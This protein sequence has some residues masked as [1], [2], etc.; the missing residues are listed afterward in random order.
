MLNPCD[1]GLDNAGAI[2]GAKLL[3]QMVKDGIEVAGADYSMV[4]GLFNG[5]KLA[6][7]IGGPWTLADAQKANINYGVAAIPTIGGKSPKVF[8][9]VQGFE[10]SAFSANKVLANLFVKDFLITKAVMLRLFELGNRPPAYLPA[11]ADLSGNADIQGF[12]AS[13]ANGTPM[14]KIPQM[15]SVWSAWS[16]ALAL[17]V[18]QT[19]DPADRDE[20]RGEPD[21]YDARLPDN[22]GFSGGAGH[23]R[24]LLL[25]MRDSFLLRHGAKILALGILCALAIYATSSLIVM[26]SYGLAALPVI[27]AGIITYIF[28]SERRYPLRWLVP[29]LLFLFV[30]VIYP[31]GYTFVGSLTDLGTGH[32][33]PK[34]QAIEQLL[35]RTYAPPNAE[36]Y[37]YLLFQDSTGSL[38]FLLQN[39]SQAI[40]V[41]GEQATA[42]TLPDARFVDENGDGQPDRFLDY[43]RLEMR[44]IVALLPTLEQ[45][46]VTYEGLTLGVDSLTEFR[47][48]MPKYSYDAAT[49]TMTDLETGTTYTAVEGIFTSPS[50]EEIYPGYRVWVGF[51]NYVRLVTNPQISGPF[52]RVFL[53][54]I[55]FA[56]LS[57][58]VT[59]AFGLGLAILL[60]DPHLRAR[61]LYRVLVIVPYAIPSF[62]TI[63]VW[64]GMLNQNFGVINQML[65]SLFGAGARVPWLESAWVARATCLLVNLWLGYPYMMIVS[66]GALQSIPHE[67]YE[68][69]RVDGASRWQ[70]FRKITLPM[71][72]MPLAPLLVG[73]FAFNFNNF[74]LIYLLTQGQP[75]LSRT[76]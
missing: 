8:V 49:E 17:I 60:N 23:G 21:P 54:T 5:G 62:V 52:V 58:A 33:L 76:H 35:G 30:M 31:I 3:D 29:G 43:R 57:V 53:W 34:N 71:L 50:G 9:G 61:S 20:E 26:G 38:A 22:V 63:L 27:A 37:T 72:L 24:P 73:S 42:I 11:L 15:D 4:T 67:L 25:P 36:R 69:S 16:D 14:P 59:F 28:L 56:A 12:A 55:A 68:A 10:I 1:I 46:R 2:A 44:E 70:Q 6:A 48:Q 19:Q 39:L 45:I 13:A 18:N 66:L 51:T 64:R 74:N 32:M 65:V 40:L 47:V 75:S 41:V 7:M